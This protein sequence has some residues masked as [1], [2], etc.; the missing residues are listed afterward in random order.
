[1]VE[2]VELT[3]A[4]ILRE[5]KRVVDKAHAHALAVELHAALAECRRRLARLPPGD[6]AMEQADAII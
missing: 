4:R 5:G 6:G 2:D 3:A 1:V